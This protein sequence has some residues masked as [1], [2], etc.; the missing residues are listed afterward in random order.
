MPEAQERPKRG[1]VLTDYGNAEQ[2]VRLHGSRLRY[3]YEFGQWFAWTGTHWRLSHSIPER[4]AKETLQFMYEAGKAN[5]S[6]EHKETLTKHARKSE[7]ARAISAMIALARSEPDIAVTPADLDTNDWLLNL[8]NGTLDLHTGLLSPHNPLDLITKLCPAPYDPSAAC[9]RWEAF[10]ARIMGGHEDLIPFLQRAVGYTLT[11]LTT[12][13]CIFIL[14]GSGDNGKTTFIEAVRALLGDDYSSVTTTQTLIAKKT[15]GIPNDIARLQGTRFVSATEIDEG[16]TLD[17]AG[18]KALTGG[19]DRL[20]ARFMRAEWF[21]FFPKFKIFLSTNHK[22]RIVGGDS[23]IWNRIRLIPFHVSIPKP[24]QNPYLIDELRSELPGILAWAVRGCLDWQANSLVSP[25]EIS[26][27]TEDY[28]DEMDILGGFISSV[29]VLGPRHQTTSNALY[30]AYRRWADHSG[31]FELCQ[32]IFSQR[33]AERGM[34]HKF[35]H[36]RLKA[37]VVW[38][39]IDVRANCFAGYDL[40]E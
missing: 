23:A 3:C 39:G 38:H 14:Y 17:E 12:E 19:R 24:E 29:C 32:R 36:K 4:L 27:A 7:A 6:P 22:P 25:L 2:L 8:S 35:Y 10:L 9:P 1:I 30:Q 28:R 21:E 37:N 16:R 40:E 13:K 26:L 31:E 20:V 11:G 18:V 5:P 34:T 15:D 33:M